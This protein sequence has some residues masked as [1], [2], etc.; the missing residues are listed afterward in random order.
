MKNALRGKGISFGLSW[1]SMTPLS[2]TSPVFHDCGTD[3]FGRLHF[4]CRMMEKQFLIL[5]ISIYHG[6]DNKV[7]ITLD[8]S[9]P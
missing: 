6:N 9:I 5:R 7:L 8:L 2:P 4:H 1:C 3:A